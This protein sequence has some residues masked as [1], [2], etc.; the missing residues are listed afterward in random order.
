M[1]KAA[2]DPYHLKLCYPELSHQHASPCNEWTQTKSPLKASST[3]NINFNAINIT[4]SSDGA[5]GSFKG[6]GKNRAG[7]NSKSVLDA[8]PHESSWWYAVGALAVENDKIPGPFDGLHHVSHVEIYM[9]RSKP[10]PGPVTGRKKRES[11][12][13]W[14]LVGSGSSLSVVKREAVAETEDEVAM[15][16]YGSRLRY[17]CGPARLFK[18]DFTG[19]LYAERWMQCNWNET[20]T[21]TDTLDECVWIECLHPPQASRTFPLPP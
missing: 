12:Q 16:S 11:A 14:A 17:Q 7:K 9:K 10:A 2:S 5:N 13:A 6:L 1:L 20:W 3:N 18:D 15:R 8:S 4:F 21:R 19:E